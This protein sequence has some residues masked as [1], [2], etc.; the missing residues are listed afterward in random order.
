MR[1]TMVMMPASEKS[2]ATSEA[3]R[4]D[5]ARSSA[6][7]PRSRVRPV[8]RLSPSRRKTFLPSVSSSSFSSASAMVV[9][10]EPESPV[11]QSVMPFW[12]I[13]LA[14]LSPCSRQSAPGAHSKM[15]FICRWSI[16]LR[17]CAATVAD[18][19]VGAACGHVGHAGGWHAGH[20]G[21]DGHSSLQSGQ[22]G[23]GA[24]SFAGGHAGHCG[25]AAHCGQTGHCLT[26]LATAAATTA[27]VSGSSRVG[28]VG[29]AGQKGLAHGLSTGKRIIVSSAPV[30]NE[31]SM[32]SR[33]RWSVRARKRRSSSGS[34]ERGTRS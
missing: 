1:V 16:L 17:C 32:E 5:S 2:A 29:Q 6:E 19:K 7:K 34:S 31:P 4:T 30:P 28:Q 22:L 13:T 25:H 8:R 10:P 14:R 9:L 11:I 18:S 20:C 24:H 23:A 27:C 33:Q 3:R 15:F 21:T 12:P 26:A